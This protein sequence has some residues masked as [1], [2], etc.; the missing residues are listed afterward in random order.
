MDDRSD[1]GPADVTDDQLVEMVARLLGIAPE[2]T[3]LL[4]SRVDE[5]DYD[6]P[7]ITTAGRHWVRG[8][9]LSGG[10]ELPFELFVKHVQA[11]SRS[12]EFNYVPVEMRPAAAAGVPW[13]TEPLAYRSDLGDRLPRGL[14]MP[15][16]VGVFDLDELSASVW[17]EVVETAE[18]TW[19][20]GRHAS[21]AHLLGR[22]AASPAVWELADVGEFSYEVSHYLDGRLR[23]MVLPLLGDE[24]VWSHPLVA[25]AFDPALRERLQRAAEL[26]PAYVEEVSALPRAASHGDACPNNLLVPA[27]GDGFVL[28]DYSF[29]GPMPVGFDL[30]QLLVGDVQVGRRGAGDLAEVED[31]ILRAYVGGLRAEGCEIPESVVRRSHALL[32]MIFTGL[33]TLPFEHLDREPTPELHRVAAER[34]AIARFCLDL[35]DAT[36]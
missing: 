13:R 8:T 23:G 6:L 19:D 22:L 3:T 29:W 28:I 18:V 16:A 17:L 32:L 1:L 34:A 31:T 35:V 24:A 21:A 7:S 11:W 27:T 26:A 2:T 33:S 12:P 20:L 30:G 4:D 10:R 25:G 14:R 15:R 9:V 5:V 36:T